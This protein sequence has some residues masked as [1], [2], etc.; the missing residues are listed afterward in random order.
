MCIC[1]C[2]CAVSGQWTCALWASWSVD[3]LGPVVMASFGMSGKAMHGHFRVQATAS[4]Y[5]KAS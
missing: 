1:V 3:A 4:H 5:N 2:V